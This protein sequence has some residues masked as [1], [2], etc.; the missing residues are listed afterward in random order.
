[1]SLFCPLE[2][3]QLTQSL[4][5][6]HAKTSATRGNKLGLKE[7]GRDCS[8]RLSESFAFFVPGSSSL[9]TSQLCLDGEWTEFSG[10][11]PRRGMMRNGQ[12]YHA[13]KWA[14]LTEE[15]ESG[16]LPILPTPTANDNDNRRTKP[17]PAEL[18]GKHGWALRSAIT[19]IESGEY[20][21]LLPTPVAN[22][23]NKSPL[24]HMKM[25]KRMKGG[26]RNTI[27]SLQV[28]CKAVALDE[29]PK[30]QESFKLLPTP[31]AI[32][33]EHPG[34]SSHKTG[35][36]LHLS[37]AVNLATPQARDWK[38]NSGKGYTE[39]GGNKNLPTQLNT[40][41]KLS[42]SFVEFM[43][44]FPIDWTNLDVDKVDE[45]FL[46]H[47]SEVV[48]SLPYSTDTEKIAHRKER[49]QAL[50][51]AVVPHCAAIALSRAK[52]IY[53]AQTQAS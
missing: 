20:H 13:Q 22:D 36:T 34:I 50:G 41:R 33:G 28:L 45:P 10:S 17:T 42:P 14:A 1:M 8:L 27:T 40:G 15:T 7:K 52:E 51:N 25:K 23:D 43:M 38:G 44:G 30:A 32:D 24:A 26:E 6:S 19:G 53:Q 4:E 16:L 47:P 12:L 9:K 3:S 31:K 11:L 37:A 35:Q 21:K 2:L 5:G 18:T 29:L 48:E 39:R 46:M 49:L